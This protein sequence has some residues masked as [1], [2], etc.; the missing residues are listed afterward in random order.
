VTLVPG[1]ALQRLHFPQVF[2]G[3]VGQSRVPEG[4]KPEM[5]QMPDVRHAVTRD[6]RRADSEPS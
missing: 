2:A 6:T 5:A 1:A 3:R 4:R